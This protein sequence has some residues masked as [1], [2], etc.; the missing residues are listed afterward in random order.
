MGAPAS[1]AQPMFPP[2]GALVDISGDD[3]TFPEPS[4]VRVGGAGN[5]KVD[6]Q[7][8]EV[9]VVL[10]SLV[11]GEYAGCLVTKVYSSANGT[12]ATLISRYW[13]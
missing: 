8:G 4:A 13:L 7:G 2:H 12:T 6:T 9:G 10:P 3:V 11:A 1:P 5:L